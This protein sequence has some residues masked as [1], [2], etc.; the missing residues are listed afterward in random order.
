ML[1][2][3]YALVTLSVEQRK[4][5]GILTAL[6]QQIRNIAKKSE[7]IDHS[8]CESILCQLAQFNESCRC[9]NLQLYMIPAVRRATRDAD[10]LLS[11]LDSFS[12]TGENILRETRANLWNIFNQGSEGVNQV[13]AAMESYCHHQLQRLVME[14]GELFPVVQR[15][16][17]S[18]NWFDIAAQFISHDAEIRAHKPNPPRGH[19]VVETGNQLSAMV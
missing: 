14:E 4:A 18:E 10:D 3:T 13:C 11:E 19:V 17:S 2:A 15:V 7:S 5:R 8:C 6:Q 12:S 9:R 16:I 1:T